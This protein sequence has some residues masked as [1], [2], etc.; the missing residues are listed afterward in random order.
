M[1]QRW[2]CQLN[3]YAYACYF[4]E[5]FETVLSSVTD[6]FMW[7]QKEKLTIRDIFDEI[8]ATGKMSAVKMEHKS[9]GRVG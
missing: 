8:K 7:K 3:A 2:L 4:F 5:I 6:S 9:I 1:W